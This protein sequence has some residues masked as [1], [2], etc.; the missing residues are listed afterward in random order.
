MLSLAKPASTMVN[1]ISGSDG[2]KSGIRGAGLTVRVLVASW[3]CGIVINDFYAV[4]KI[5][6]LFHNHVGVTNLWWL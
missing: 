5:R 3:F 1:Q 2:M 4:C 6:E